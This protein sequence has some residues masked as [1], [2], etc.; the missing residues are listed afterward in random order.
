MM[1][2]MIILGLIIVGRGMECIDWKNFGFIVRSLESLEFF[3]DKK[4]LKWRRGGILGN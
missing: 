1:G 4:D 3:F 2:Y